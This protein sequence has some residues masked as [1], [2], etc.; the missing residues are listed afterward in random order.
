M[1][2]DERDGEIIQSGRQLDAEILEAGRQLARSA[3]TRPSAFDTAMAIATRDAP[4][5]VALFRTV[6]VAPACRT[7]RELAEHLAA[8]LAQAPRRS[9]LHAVAAR[10]LAHPSLWP[11]AGRATS[12]AVRRMAG[13]FIVGRDVRDAAP[14]LG[15]MWTAGRAASIDLLGEA[16]VTRA[17]GAA[18]ADRCDEALAQLARDAARLP[19]RPLLEHDSAGPLPRVNLAIKV[20][21]LTPLVRAAAPERGRDD[22]AGH[23]RRLLRRAREVGAHLHVDMESMDSAAL[24]EELVLELLAEREFRDGPSAGL[25]LQA[26]LAD[27]DDRLERIVGWARSCGR[28]VPLTVR[29]VKGAYWDHE[30]TIAAQS[31]W[32]PPVWATQPETDRCFERCTDALIG[33]FPAVRPAIASHNLRSLAHAMVSARHAGLDRGDVEY[34]VLRGLGDDLAAAIAAAGLRGRTYCPVGDLVAGMA[35]LVRRLLENTQSDSFLARRHAGAG[36]ERLLAAP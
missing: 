5:R 27:A 8:F 13:R 3:R 36:V 2:R 15:R 26:Y 17:E 33:A 34:Q 7:S 19:P 21:A 6:E 14:V 32:R 10:T 22:A 24:V 12:L 35:Y 18:Y 28:S 29:L 25:V 9:R 31:G 11:L 16:T 20:T 30:T 1:G 4:L 23:V